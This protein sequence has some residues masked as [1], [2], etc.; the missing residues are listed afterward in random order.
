VAES[1]TLNPIEATIPVSKTQ[2]NTSV[3]EPKGTITLDIRRDAKAVKCVI[4]LT[5]PG[6]AEPRLT[7]PICKGRAPTH[8]QRY[9]CVYG[10][11][12]TAIVDEVSVGKMKNDRNTG[13]NHPP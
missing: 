3:Q 1:V 11:A 10:V 7:E 2:N 8:P 6:F 4:C 12:E 9:C 5:E 13:S